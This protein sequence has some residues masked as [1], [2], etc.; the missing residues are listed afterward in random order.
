MMNGETHENQFT[1]APHEQNQEVIETM[2]SRTN[3]GKEV[4]GL[5][6]SD[7][8][9]TIET[10]VWESTE[11]DF[12]SFH[13]DESHRDELVPPDRPVGYVAP[14]FDA[15]DDDST[16]STRVGISFTQL[17]AEQPP[18]TASVIVWSPWILNDLM[19]T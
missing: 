3:P 1:G 2:E 4:L 12:A 11:A 17:L 10:V 8:T 16:S 15:S 19:A 7:T 5:D 14:D 18:M 9:Q 13:S 6:L